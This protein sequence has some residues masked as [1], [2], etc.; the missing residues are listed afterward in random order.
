[1]HIIFLDTET[2][3]LEQARL[4]QLAYK[5]IATGLV[6]NEYFKPPVPISYGA[7]ATHHVTNEMVAEKPIFQNSDHYVDLVETLKQAVVVA[8]NA[9]FDMQVLKNEGIEVG[10]HIDTLRVARHL[11]KSDQYALQYLRYFL[12]LNVTGAAHDALGDVLVLEA[13]FNHLKTVVA[14]K[15]GLTTDQEILEQMILLTQ[16]PALLGAFNF[17]KYKGKTFEDVHAQ[18]KGYLEWLYN[19]E[20]QKNPTDQNKELVFTLKHYLKV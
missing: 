17:G 9:P 7:M 15:F 16:T 8:H 19:S 2:T 10:P 3:D 11:L 1:M 4:I 6:V 5:N 20:N 18:D 13:L 14:E 12:N